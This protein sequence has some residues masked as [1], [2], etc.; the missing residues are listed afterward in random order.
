MDPLSLETFVQS[1]NPIGHN[2][3]PTPA[4]AQRIQLAIAEAM[5]DSYASPQ[6]LK[7]LGRFLTQQTYDEVVEERN[8]EHECGYLICNR[9][10]LSTRQSSPSKYQIYN[11]KPSMVLPNTYLSQYCCKEHYQALIFYRNQLLNEALFLR[12]GVLT[13]PIGSLS[14]ER[15]TFLEDVLSKHRELKDEG[16]SLLD[17]VA[18]MSGLTVDDKDDTNELVR[19]IEDFEIVE[20]DGDKDGKDGEY[21]T[22]DKSWG[23]EYSH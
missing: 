17:V 23:G 1:I 13:E 4:D 18:M 15:I 7:F 2:D 5:V 11:R 20:K 6:L 16:H 12:K 10:P 19:L 9:S 3:P 22:D 8:I 21:E 14:Y